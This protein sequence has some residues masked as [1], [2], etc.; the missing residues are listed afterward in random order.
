LGRIFSLRS[1]VD[2]VK[3]VSKIVLIAWVAY[4]TVFNN[5]TEALILVDTSVIDAVLYLARIA[6]LIL[7]KVCGILILIAFMD[8]LYTR[9]EMEEKMKMTKQE[10]MALAH[11]NH[12]SPPEKKESQ[13]ICFIKEPSFS[14]FIVAHTKEDTFQPGPI[15]TPAGDILGHHKGLHCYTV[16]QRRGLNCPGPAPYYVKKIDMEKN[17]LVV[18]FKEDL[19]E[20]HFTVNQVNWLLSTPL[21]KPMTVE[22]RIR[23]S[24]KGENRTD[25][26]LQQWHYRCAQSTPKTL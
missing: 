4:T 15:V 26:C 17:H 9:Y 19:L 12:L 5:F 20:S 22:V 14:D 8:F 10:V 13:D 3:S 11:A 1:L 6:T 24:H 2:L 7:A 23:Y 16:G 25:H 18:G 21:T